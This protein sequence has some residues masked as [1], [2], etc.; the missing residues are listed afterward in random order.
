LFAEVRLPTGEAAVSSTL[1]IK[2]PHC[3]SDRLVVGSLVRNTGFR[4]QG[5][6]IPFL[7]IE[8][9]DVKVPHEATACLDCGMLWTEIDAQ[10]LRS[11]L[12]DLGRPEVKQQLRL[13]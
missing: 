7:S 9:P 6:K 12:V 3:G 13:E 5:I 8:L 1:A 2:C 4:P 10:S 11:K